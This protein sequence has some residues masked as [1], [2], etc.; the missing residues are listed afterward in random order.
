MFSF[1]SQGTKFDTTHSKGN[2]P[3]TLRLHG[4][5]YHRIG[6]LLLEQGNPP[7]YSQLYIFEIDNEVDNRMDYF[8]ENKNVKR[9][10]VL[11]LKYMLDNC[12][13][14]AKAFRMTRDMLK[15]N[16][17]LDLKLK[18]I[19]ARPEDVRVYNRPTISEVGTLIV[20]HIVSG[21]QRDVII[22]ARDGNLKKIDE[23]HPCYLACQYPL[24]FFSGDDGYRDNIL[25]MYKNEH[26]IIRKN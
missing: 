6:T 5:T 2:G 23:L 24:I 13:V 17:F 18:L 20:G 11:E 8:R 26:L 10:V 19:A 21:S 12:N 15:E 9:E 22:Q 25:H 16:S 4:Q 14:H 1:T 3:P 7:K